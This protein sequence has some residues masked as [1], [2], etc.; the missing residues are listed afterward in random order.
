MS[1]HNPRQKN[2]FD[3]QTDAMYMSMNIPDHFPPPALSLNLCIALWDSKK[4]ITKTT[5]TSYSVHG[6]LK[7]NLIIITAGLL[8]LKWRFIKLRHV[9]IFLAHRAVFRMISI[10]KIVENFPFPGTWYP[11]I[12]LDISDKFI[13]YIFPLQ[14]TPFTASC[15]G[16]SHKA[17]WFLY[18]GYWKVRYKPS[19]SEFFHQMLHSTLFTW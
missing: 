14:E 16:V 9:V 7:K 3:F 13:H 5:P 17:V 2:V 15:K 11:W 12:F 10:V 18:T 6:T 1:L 19:T 4:A 8:F